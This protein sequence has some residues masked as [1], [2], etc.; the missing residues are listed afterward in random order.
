MQRKITKKSEKTNAKVKT[1]LHT[2]LQK[3]GEK[4]I[5]S[6]FDRLSERTRQEVVKYKIEVVGIAH[7]Q[8][9][10]QALFA[11][12]KLLHD[13]NYRGNV[14]GSD[15]NGQDNAFWF[16]GYLP[17][18][19]FKTSKYLE[20]YGVGKRKT[21]RGKIEF[22]VNERR[23]ALQ[24][25]KDL[26]IKMN[27][28]IY[29]KIYW[30]IN[31]KG[32]KEQHRARIETIAP[33]IRITRGWDALTKKESQALNKQEETSKTDDKLIAIGI[34]P[35]PILI[36]Q[37][38]TYFILKPANYRE[39][40]ALTSEEF[41]VSKYT[42][43]FIDYLMAQAELKRRKKQELVIT[44]ALE[45]LAY[46]LRL[47]TYVKKRY[48]KRIR[49][50]L[51]NSCKLAKALGYLL[52]YKISEGEKDMQKFILNPPKFDRAL[53]ILEQRKIIDESWI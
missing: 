39:E 14:L 22:N 16:R 46:K 29:E 51:N 7:T 33:L 43:L 21:S 35:C 53:A 48:F 15:Y 38:D 52:E 26:A 44:I 11:I 45:N 28:F 27:L 30:I 50:I 2:E 4:P 3:F 10:Q 47:A 19:E 36:D 5:P 31:K 8:A 9:Q 32:K 23:E 18:L 34:E 24:A 1:S 17:A 37:I 42:Y 12:Q 40:I 41:K 13:T 6:I 25:L 49:Q 20:A